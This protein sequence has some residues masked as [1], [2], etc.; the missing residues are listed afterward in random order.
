MPMY[1]Y[2]CDDCGG[3]NTILVYSWSK[4]TDRACRGCSGTN[5]VKL[6]SGFTMR[7][8]W[9]DSLNWAPSG[10]TLSDVNEDD[11]RSVDRFMGRIQQEMGGQVTS[12]FNDMRRDWSSGPDSHGHDHGHGHSHPH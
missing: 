4:D 6:I 9:G 1:E 7:R 12:D 5:L 8:S 10:E 11:P 2:R 3:R